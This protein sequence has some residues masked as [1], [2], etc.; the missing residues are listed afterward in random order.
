MLSL[1]PWVQRAFSAHQTASCAVSRTICLSHQ[2][3]LLNKITKMDFVSLG[4]CTLYFVAFFLIVSVV[5][6]HYQIHENLKNIPQVGRYPIGAM[7]ELLNLSNYGSRPSTN[8]L[9]LRPT[10]SPRKALEILK[11]KEASSNPPSE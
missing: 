2:G 7:F 8:A 3:S 11:P 4:L 5:H 10:R 1:P 9:L 6:R